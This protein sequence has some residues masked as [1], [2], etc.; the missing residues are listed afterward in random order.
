MY[1]FI[2]SV[3]ENKNLYK[4]KKNT[5]KQR[6]IH[7]CHWNNLLDDNIDDD[8]IVIREDIPLNYLFISSI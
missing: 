2:V 7:R 1:I 3:F 6:W 4:N 5:Y 8:D